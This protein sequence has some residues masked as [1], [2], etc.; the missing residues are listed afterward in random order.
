M[1]VAVGTGL[2]IG[3]CS[4]SMTIP[5]SSLRLVATALIVAGV[6]LCGAETAPAAATKAKAQAQLNSTSRAE[7]QRK[8]SE[9][10]DAMI[11]SHEALA[12]QLKD[13]T[14]AQRKAILENM[15][16]EKKKFEEM[17]N[18]LHKQ[19]RDEIRELR[20]NAGPGKR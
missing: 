8:V 1:N 14:E 16:A 12:K 6:S 13:A 4:L 3:V 15:Q 11:A 5:R 10:R 20:Q 17:M 18:A 7:V 19:I 9:Q 2:A